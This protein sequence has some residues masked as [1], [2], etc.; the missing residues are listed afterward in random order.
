MSQ[1][2]ERILVAVKPWEHSL[3]VSIPRVLQL[4]QGLD[5]EVALTSCIRLSA[6]SDALTWAI[7]G[8]GAPVEEALLSQA[9]SETEALE[10]LAQPLQDHG[11]TV[12]THVRSDASASRGILDEVAEWRADL[13]IAGVHEPP[14]AFRP[15]LATV[16][17]QLMRLCPCP[18]LLARAS[19]DAPYRT[20]IAAVD[21]LHGH[22]EPEGLDH[23]IL[24]VSRHFRDAFNA[25][26]RLVNVHPDPEEYE[27]A[28]SV[29]VSPGVF[30]GAENMEALHRQALIDL[31]ADC[32]VADAELV[33]RAGKP[34]D[35][36]A[37]LAAEPA[38]DLA[39]L[40]AIKR[41]RLE[42]V[43]LGS[44]AERVVDDG[45]C[46]VLLLKPPAATD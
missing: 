1:Q 27:V 33:L 17:W 46:D 9:N 15:R 14:P 42:S 29:E 6:Q 32:G 23:A 7:A 5:A 43:L 19:N 18:L 30:Y 41:G 10:R 34:A 21:P 40:G 13:L 28:S 16:D 38:T 12:T 36:V 35:V 3:P 25:D 45:Q 8:Q 11:V 22:A 31:A 39:V 20:I 26:L 44:T 2:I 24:A 4:A 37:G